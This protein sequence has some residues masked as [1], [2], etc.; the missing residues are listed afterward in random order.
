MN[1]FDGVDH[2][3]GAK[4]AA[5]SNDLHLHA[6]SEERELVANLDLFSQRYRKE[7]SKRDR[8][9]PAYWAYLRVTTTSQTVRNQIEDL[10]Q[11]RTNDSLSWW[12]DRKQLDGEYLERLLLKLD[13][14]TKPKK[15]GPYR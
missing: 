4:T 7:G 3:P 13:H 8:L 2:W 9:L 12:L 14:R 10:A 11:L 15:R 1:L 5:F 6:H